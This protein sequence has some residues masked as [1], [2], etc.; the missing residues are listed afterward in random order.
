MKFVETNTGKK[1]IVT[2]S[3]Y[4]K[5]LKNNIIKESYDISNNETFNKELSQFMDGTG[6]KPEEAPAFLGLVNSIRDEI[7]NT[8][9]SPDK[10]YNML[11]QAWNKAKSNPELMQQYAEKQATNDS[12]AEK[13]TSKPTLD[14]QELIDKIISIAK[15]YG[16]ITATTGKAFE[17]K[18]DNNLEVIVPAGRE[19]AMVKVIRYAVSQ[20]TNDPTAVKI[21]QGVNDSKNAY[22]DKMNTEY[23]KSYSIPLDGLNNVLNIDIFG[24]KQGLIKDIIG[25]MSLSS[26]TSN[27]MKGYNTAMS[28]T[29]KHRTQF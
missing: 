13:Q 4:K 20:S 23:D 18:D 15:K 3:L 17:N 8:A 25:D 24:K 14:R 1:T 9:E 5:L 10:F 28:N 2:E 26:I 27:L 11:S 22:G 16:V 21:K 19:S 12:T 7:G 6:V 29:G